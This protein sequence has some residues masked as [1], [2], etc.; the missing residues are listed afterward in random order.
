MDTIRV[1]YIKPIL[2]LGKYLNLYYKNTGYIIAYTYL[3]IEFGFHRY[4]KFV[5]INWHPRFWSQEKYK[6]ISMT[7]WF[8]SFSITV[9]KN[10]L[11]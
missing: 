1:N 9:N 6:S 5:F 8:L 11:K 10:P 4:S 3:N 2:S 7:L